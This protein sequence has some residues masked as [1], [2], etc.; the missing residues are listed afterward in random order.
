MAAAPPPAG[1]LA[2]PAIPTARRPI[3]AYKEAKGGGDR[4][5]KKATAAA[6]FAPIQSQIPAR[7]QKCQ[8]PF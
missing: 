2:S 7:E 8:R 6:F 3:D 4:R 1:A 5:R